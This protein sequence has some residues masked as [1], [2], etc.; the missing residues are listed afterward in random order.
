MRDLQE[1]FRQAVYLAVGNAPELIEFGQ[2]HRFPTSTRAID[3]AGWCK[4]FLDG[5]AGVYGDHRTGLSGV[6]A[7]KST[8]PPTLAQRQQRA[9]ELRLARAEAAAMQSAQWALA[10][11]R[12]A[13]TWRL[14]SPVKPGDPVVKYLEGRGIDLDSWP[15][16]L[17]HH[18]HL[19]YFD[20]DRFMGLHPAMLGAVTDATG[21]LISVHRTYLTRGGHKADL[22][23]IKKLTGCSARLTGCSVKLFP[24]SLDHGK[25][26]IGVAEGIETA[27]ACFAAWNTP[28]VSAISAQGL[29]S[30]QWPQ[31][32]TNIIIHADN[33]LSQVGQRAAQTLA[34]RARKAGLSEQVVTPPKSG[35]DWADVWAGLAEAM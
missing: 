29:A 8:K 5:R 10:A 20:G 21:Q 33:D 6:W 34:Q 11:A 7:A 26:S 14:A 25:L 28:M 4:L 35:T 13:E 22:P 3:K 16:A 2:M 24:P 32:M 31:E 17:R 18:S 30:Y 9:D 12:N 15:E 19:P 1:N 27:L 23:V